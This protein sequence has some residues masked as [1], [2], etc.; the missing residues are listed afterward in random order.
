MKKRNKPV[1][2]DTVIYK[3]SAFILE[4]IFSENERTLVF[5]MTNGKKKYLYYFVKSNFEKLFADYL[6]LSKTGI[7]LPG[8]YEMNEEDNFLVTEYPEGINAEKLLSENNLTDKT[9]TLLIDFIAIL[10]G[11]NL[12]VKMYPENFII[13]GDKIICTCFELFDFDDEIE[14]I[15]MTMGEWGIDKN[16]EE[17]KNILKSRS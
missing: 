9:R 3:E 7:E 5:S 8:I 17:F 6:F 11:N 2:G 12:S 1:A 15:E 14:N 13:S 4:R 10:A 16:S